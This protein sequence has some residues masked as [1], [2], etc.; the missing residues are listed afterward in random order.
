MACGPN[1]GLVG[2]TSDG[3]SGGE[4]TSTGRASTSSGADSSTGQTVDTGQ[5]STTRPPGTTTD[6]SESST[7]CDPSDS[8]EDTE[9][10]GACDPN[11]DG[12][13]GHIRI[14][15][16]EEDYRA[17]DVD[18]S[19]DVTTTKSRD[20]TQTIVEVSCPSGSV[21]L[22][23][24][25]DPPATLVPGF[26]VGQ[27][28]QIRAFRDGFIDST[29]P[30]HVAIRDDQGSLIA[31]YSNHL[32]VPKSVDPDYLDW[33]APLTFSEVDLGCEATAPPEPPACGFIVDPCP[34]GYELRG[35]EFSDGVEERLVTGPS[36][37]VLGPFELRARAYRVYPAPGGECSDAPYNQASWAAF[38]VQ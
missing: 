28:L 23:L 14:S 26:A 13:Y 24:Y 36:G 21:L 20:P 34:S 1:V 25:M 19:C 18:A 3:A 7:A 4:G 35:L 29:P 6:T 8:G 22:E 10:L 37:G 15:R 16:I 12:L 2:S 9:G 30:T 33:F 38:R 31:A 32:P 27:T 17:L 11:Q 5:T